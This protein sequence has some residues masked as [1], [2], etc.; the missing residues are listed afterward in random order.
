MTKIRVELRK[1]DAK[2][3]MGKNT[4]MRASLNK[5]LSKPEEGDDDYET[6]KD[7]FQERPELQQFVKLLRGNTG[8]I[9]TNGNLSAIKEVLDQEKRGAP[10]K[11]GSIAP[12]DVWIRTGP[13]GLDPKQTSFF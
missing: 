7:T 3:L 8:I 5:F 2:M 10:A 12:E 4:L 9:F 6:R 13:T 11:A 1:M